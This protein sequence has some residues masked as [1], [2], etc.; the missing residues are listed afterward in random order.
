VGFAALKACSISAFTNGTLESTSLFLWHQ[1]VVRAPGVVS[2]THFGTCPRHTPKCAR[3]RSP[4]QKRVQKLNRQRGIRG[5]EMLQ[6]F[7][8]HRDAV[9][10][11][12][13]RDQSRSHSAAEIA[14]GNGRLPDADMGRISVAPTSSLARP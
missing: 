1:Q 10:M 12:K 4:D 2:R 3:L 11:G 14:V 9:V 6:N 5:F 7:G 13:C 8:A